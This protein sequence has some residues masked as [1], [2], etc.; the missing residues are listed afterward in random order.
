MSLRD[1]GERLRREVEKAIQGQ[2]DAIEHLLVGLLASGHVL[3]EGV[4]GTGKTL[5]TKALVRAMGGEFRRVQFTPDLMPSDVLGTS[6]WNDERREFLLRKGPIFADVVLGDE[7]NRAPPKTQAA[8]LEAMEE[9]QVT[10]D[11]QRLELPRTFF[12]VA[13]RNPV[14]YEGTYPLPEAQLDRFL[15]LVKF[16]YPDAESERRLLEVG[17]RPDRGHDLDALG[18]TRVSEP[19]ELLAARAELDSIVV[20]PETVGYLLDV[21]HRT[22]SSPDVA[23][24]ASPRAALAWLAGAKAL[25]AMRGSP[26]V[27]PDDVKDIAHAILRHR[28]L[29]QPEAEMAGA[30]PDDVIDE[31]LAGAKVPR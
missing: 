7:I 18:V 31:V 12:V 21:V 4:P 22:R 19:A 26:H 27:T 11:G 3:L 25:A 15:L 5:A 6:V 8:F 29:L 28:L 14:E 24:G 23:L 30:N 2:D 9:R 10:I 20:A 17:R 13:T 1:L 16:G